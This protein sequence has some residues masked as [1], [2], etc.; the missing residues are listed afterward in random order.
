M[1]TIFSLYDIKD[2]VKQILRFV[3]KH[4]THVRKSLLKTC[5]KTVK[6][7]DVELWS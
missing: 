5:E 6:P 3:P 2:G 4:I 1:H 7:F